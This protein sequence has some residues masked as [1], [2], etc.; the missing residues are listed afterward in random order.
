PRQRRLALGIAHATA[1]ALENARLIDSL[2]AASRLKSEFVATMSHELRTPLNVITGYTDMLREGAAGTLTDEQEEMVARMQRSAAE[3]LDLG[4]ATLDAGR[5]EAG[6]EVVTRA[7][8][9]L[10]PLLAEIAREV[11][12]LIADGVTLYWDVD[13]RAPVNTDRVK[14]KTILKNL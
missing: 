6:R 1:I 11:E 12:P 2:Q 9:E 3:L 4:S 14:V 8:V 7:S 5:L 10:R 13:V